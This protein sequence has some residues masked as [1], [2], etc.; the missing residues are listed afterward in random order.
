[1]KLVNKKQKKLTIVAIVAAIVV[2]IAVVAIVIGVTI[3]NN[4]NPENDDPNTIRRITVSSH[5]KL[6]YVVGEAFDP[7][8][9]KVQVITNSNDTTYFVDESKLTFSGFDS[10][11]A[12]DSLTI[13]V[14]YQGFIT[15]YTVQIKEKPGNN[16][17]NNN[18]GNNGQGNTSNL[19]VCDMRVTYTL[20]RWNG[21]GPSTYG[22]Y[23]KITKPDG[24]VYGSLDETPLKNSDIYG[25]EK[26]DKPCEF[27]LTIIYTDRDG[28]E[29]TATVTVTITN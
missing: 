14:G 15:T 24:T 10:S 4:S 5:P 19:E 18:Q 1:M 20:D 26:V 22:A 16:Q 8:G 9:I 17:G 23:V 28:K 27:D 6:E 21:R 25:Y 7:S 2:L 12:N 29:Y 3:N 13:V 11:V